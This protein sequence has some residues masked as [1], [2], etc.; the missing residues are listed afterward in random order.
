[1]KIYLILEDEP[2]QGVNMKFMRHLE[3]EAGPETVTP[4]NQ[5]AGVLEEMIM[6]LVVEARGVYVTD[7][8]TLGAHEC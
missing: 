3:G 6:D 5:I 4:A 8:H 2:N 7:M 1:M